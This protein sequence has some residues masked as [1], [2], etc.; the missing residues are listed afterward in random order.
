MSIRVS[1]IPNE[2]CRDFP[3]VL[4]DS[5]LVKQQQ[6]YSGS[7]PFQLNHYTLRSQETDRVAK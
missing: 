2:V 6:L 7:V 1:A 4:W 3:Q 5:N